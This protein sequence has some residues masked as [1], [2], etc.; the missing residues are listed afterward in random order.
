MRSATPIQS[1]RG[2]G[3][4]R[5]ARGGARG[6]RSNAGFSL[7]ELLGVIVV[8]G[9]VATIVSINWRAILPRTELHSA[10]RELA[11]VLQG[12]RSD[13]I[14]RNAVFEVHYDLDAH[15]YRVVTP[16]RADGG[17]APRAEDRQALAWHALPESVRFQTIT[18]GGTPYL[19][20]LVLARFDPLGSASGHTIV[21]EQ[22]LQ[23]N[24]YT[25]EVQALLGLITYHE[26]LFERPVPVE[27]D[28]K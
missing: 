10:V 19:K 4:T 8:L 25:V 15:R 14:A 17:L 5:R 13:A 28:F 20:G 27:D 1:V 22:P 6:P 11:G 21:L 7:I 24:V 18:I 2:A 16:F 12:T 26:G 23:G 9:L 3:W